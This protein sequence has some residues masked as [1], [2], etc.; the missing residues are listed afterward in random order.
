MNKILLK[1]M[2]GILALQSTIHATDLSQIDFSRMSNPQKQEYVNTYTITRDEILLKRFPQ[3]MKDVSC[4]MIIKGCANA[5]ALL[6]EAHLIKRI[7]STEIHATLNNIITKL[8]QDPESLLWDFQ[9][10]FGLIDHLKDTE[11]RKRLFL[12]LV[13]ETIYTFLEKDTDHHCVPM[14][15]TTNYILKT[16][17]SSEQE[18][19]KVLNK[20]QERELLI[21]IGSVVENLE[22]TVLSEEI[23]NAAKRNLELLKQAQENPDISDPDY[24]NLWKKIPFSKDFTIRD[25]AGQH[26]TLGRVI[27]LVFDRVKAFP[28][29]MDSFISALNNDEAILECGTGALN[30]FLLSAKSTLPEPESKKFE[31]EDR[32]RLIHS[33][34]P[35]LKAFILRLIEST[36][37]P[38]S[39]ERFHE[40]DSMISFFHMLKNSEFESAHHEKYKPFILDLGFKIYFSEYMQPYIQDGSLSFEEIKE[41]ISNIARF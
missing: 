33:E 27:Q 36:E 26:V 8:V 1:S 30:V 4:K 11:F 19:R 5:Q 7:G 38:F 40:N 2:I 31:Q 39:D 17:L 37:M 28:S 41:Y 14:L 23:I 29:L 34:L 12:M 22:T 15:T 24:G 32:D 20:D 9:T 10:R 21:E 3:D 16:L 6:Q 35:A 13:F 25:H 18:E